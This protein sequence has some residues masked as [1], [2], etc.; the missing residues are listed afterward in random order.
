[1]KLHL[2]QAAGAAAPRDCGRGWRSTNEFAG[3]S[4]AE[5]RKLEL[6][7]LPDQARH[8]TQTPDTDQHLF[9]VG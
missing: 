9:R 8:I 3:T 2:W 5:R 4:R 6:R 7:G 1:M